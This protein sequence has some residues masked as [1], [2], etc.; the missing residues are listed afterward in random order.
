[1]FYHALHWKGICSNV[2]GEKKW[3]EKPSFIKWWPG[4]ANIEQRKR[5]TLFSSSRRRA[6]SFYRKDYVYRYVWGDV[7]WEKSK[8]KIGQKNKL[9]KKIDKTIIGGE[10]NHK[11]LMK[12]IQNKCDQCLIFEN[13][14][15][16]A[17]IY[18]GVVLTLCQVCTFPYYTSILTSKFVHLINK[19][20]STHLYSMSLRPGSFQ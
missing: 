11:I 7:R 5:G 8:L 1:M 19:C 18:I 15:A 4:Q 3:G 9:G 2:D 17:L 20:I 14:N 6:T 13:G 16:E 10:Q 12:L